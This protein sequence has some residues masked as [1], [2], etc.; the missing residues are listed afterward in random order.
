VERYGTARDYAS[1]SVAARLAAGLLVMERWLLLVGIHDEQVGRFVEH[2]WAWLAVTPDTFAAWNAQSGND[3][4]PVALGHELPDRLVGVCRDARVPSQDLAEMIN[5]VGEVLYFSMFGAFDDAG[6]LGELI[7]LE[8]V[9]GQY[10]L[11]LPA[12]PLFATSPVTARHGWGGRRVLH[13]RW[14]PVSGRCV[15]SHG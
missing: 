2:L 3:V 15:H 8:R 4:Y 6:V 7:G 12:A 10:G 14:H 13:H 9:A 1:L 5:R 11:G